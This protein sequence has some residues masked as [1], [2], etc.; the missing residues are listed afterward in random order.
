M[1]KL[2]VDSFHQ[3]FRA[4]KIQFTVWIDVRDLLSVWVTTNQLKI[5]HNEGS[6]DRTGIARGN[7]KSPTT[8]TL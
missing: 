5:L 6:T 1:L 8:H 3:G 4:T 7:S 2:D